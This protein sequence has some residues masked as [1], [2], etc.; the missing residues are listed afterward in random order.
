MTNRL[1]LFADRV[2]TGGPSMVESLL[3]AASSWP[4]S[5]G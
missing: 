4:V 1:A 3:A 5:V 2:S